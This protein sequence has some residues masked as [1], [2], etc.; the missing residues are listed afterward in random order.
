M[1]I[2]LLITGLEQLSPGLSELK[3]YGFLIFSRTSDGFNRFRNCCH[4]PIKT[5]ADSWAA[6]A[7]GAVGYVPVV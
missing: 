7:G 2:F 4:R 1:D 3:I 6:R 5:L